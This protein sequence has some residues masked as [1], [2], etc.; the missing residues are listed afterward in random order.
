MCAEF[1]GRIFK[2][3]GQSV[4]ST[5]EEGVIGYKN[6]LNLNMETQKCQQAQERN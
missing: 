5:S 4:A 3:H 6:Q 1:G 2:V